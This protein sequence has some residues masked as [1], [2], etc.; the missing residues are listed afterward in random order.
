MLENQQTKNQIK[1]DEHVF[2]AG[3]TG[4][5]KTAVASVYLA[6]FPRVVKMDEK[7]DALRDIREGIS[8][9]S[10]VDQ[11]RL[12]VVT[13]LQHLQDELQNKERTHIIYCADHTEINPTSHNLFYRMCYDAEDLTVWTDEL[14]AVS[15]NPQVIPEY[16]QAIYTRGRTRN[17][18]SWG[19]TQRPKGISSLPVSQSTHV[20]GFNLR[21]PDDRKRMVE[22]TGVP[23]FQYNPGLYKFWYWND[24]MDNAIKAQLEM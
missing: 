4:S 5:G 22:L 15:P 12:A 10:M 8:P 23:E 20:F 2:I 16:L 1:V 19:L 3:K 6:G 21:L 14:F 7:G 17:V 18:S 9:W 13:S 24:R 11:K